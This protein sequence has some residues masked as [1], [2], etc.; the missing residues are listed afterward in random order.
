MRYFQRMKFAPFTHSSYRVFQCYLSVLFF[1]VS[2]PALSQQTITPVE[3]KQ[4]QP[5]ANLAFRVYQDA[6]ILDWDMFKEK[7][8]FN[9]FYARA[10]EHKTTKEVVIAFEGTQGWFFD[11][12]QNVNSFNPHYHLNKK[13]LLVE[14][15]TSDQFD[16]TLMFIEEVRNIKSIDKLIGHSLGGALAQYAS[17]HYNIPS[18][19]FNNLGLVPFGVGLNQG[20]HKPTIIN[21][22]SQGFIKNANKRIGPV[23][24]IVYSLS[25]G[26]HS[27]T[28]FYVPID[29]GEINPSKL[30]LFEE[31]VRSAFIWNQLNDVWKTLTNSIEFISDIHNMRNLVKAI[32]AISKV[33]VVST[34]EA[35]LTEIIV[36]IDSS[37]SMEKTDPRNLRIDAIEQLVY[38][39]P[40]NVNIGIIDFDLKS[41]LLSPPIGVGQWGSKQ[42]TRLIRAAKLIDSDGGT[43]IVAAVKLARQKRSISNSQFLLLSDGQDKTLNVRTLKDLIKTDIPIH[44]IALSSASDVDMLSRLASHTGGNYEYADDAENLNRVIQNLF[45]TAINQQVL[46]VRSDS[47]NQDQTLTYEVVLESGIQTVSFQNSW[48]GSD[49][50]LTVISPSGH[51]TSIKQAISQNLGVEAPTYDLI[52]IN[53]PQ[54]GLWTIKL[55]G[56]DLPVSEQTTTRVFTNNSPQVISLVENVTVPEKNTSYRI[57]HSKD[58]NIQWQNVTGVLHF[59]DG[60]I[61][62]I[63]KAP[64]YINQLFQNTE[65]QLLWEFTPEQLGNYRAELVFKGKTKLG[66]YIQR[67]INKTIQV[68]SKGKG[69]KK[70]TKL[71]PLIPRNRH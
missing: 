19:L 69:V 61:Q 42:R 45:G 7:N 23:N 68:R 32:T 25:V 21:V 38:A 15:F 67:A 64:D 55:L 1:F 11:W 36:L 46:L 43:N 39:A 71:K 30:N 58:N 49:V 53:N 59:P 34:S 29:L 27:G 50:D 17:T 24:D 66:E 9:G 14:H 63:N 5:Y 18:I 2:F 52:R 4:I 16:S 51:K 40:D 35:V 62:K 26:G 47:I 70:Q 44:T 41:T 31:L 6:S 54:S 13:N 33:E 57:S 65:E 37:G 60:K 12:V 22:V 3:A 20:I 8:L 48:R 10:Y 28:T 56:V